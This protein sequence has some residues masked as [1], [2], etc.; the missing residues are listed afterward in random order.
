MN[1]IFAVSNVGDD[2]VEALQVVHGSLFGMVKQHKTIFDAATQKFVA[3]VSLTDEN[4]EA[5][6][7]KTKQEEQY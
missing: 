4:P 3:K 5:A 7:A 6:K 1:Q 2:Q